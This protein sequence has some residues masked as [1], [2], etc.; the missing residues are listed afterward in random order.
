MMSTTAR[1]PITAVAAPAYRWV[2]LFV[3]WLG[4]L[5]SF[6]DR[7]TWANVAVSVGG[8]LGL[9]VAALGIFVTAFYVGYVICNA[10]GGMASDRVGARLTL[11]ISLMLLGVSTFLFSFTASVGFGLVLQGLMGLA[12]G[13][14]YASSIKLIVAWFDR[15][16]RGRAMG[17]LLIASSLGVTATNAV[18][19]TLAALAGWQG[20]YRALGLVTLAVGAIAFLLLRDR[21]AGTVQNLAARVP[22]RRLLGNRNLLLL[23]LVGFAAFWGTWGFAFWANALMIKGR[24]FSAIQAG[25]VVSLVGIAA[26]IGKPLIGLLSDWMGGRCKWLSFATLV[27]F[28]VMLMIFGTLTDP[29][30]FAFAAPLVGLGAFLYSPLL[31]AMVAETSGV[32]LAGSAAGVLASFWQLG[33]VIVPVVV[34]VVFQATGSFLAAFATLAAGPALAA[35]GLLFVKE[36]SD[37][38]PLS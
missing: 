6:V 33:S 30:A 22:V 7:L 35:I 11:S 2:V 16:S 32:A 14:D 18:V 17:I 38:I 8:S 5:L 34:G 3:A 28:V 26:I 36:G 10:L 12:A 21:P 27:L 15:T 25:G 24:G 1:L 20:V 37:V 9:P 29:M 4:F 13:A 19:P 23:G 31:A